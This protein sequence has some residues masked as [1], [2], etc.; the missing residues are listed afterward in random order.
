MKQ[1]EAQGGAPAIT[2]RAT[3]F[4]AIADAMGV[5]GIVVDNVDGLRSALEPSSPGPLVVDA[6]INPDSYRHVIRTIRG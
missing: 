3:D 6:R 1:R 2:Y 4:A 5:P